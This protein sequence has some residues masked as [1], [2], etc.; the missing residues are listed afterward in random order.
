MIEQN[1]ITE[2]VNLPPF[3]RESR[4]FKH[5]GAINKIFPHIGLDNFELP[6]SKA[7]HQIPFVFSA[8]SE[9]A[10]LIVNIN[11]TNGDKIPEWLKC[12]GVALF[13][14][15]LWTVLT[16]DMMKLVRWKK[17]H[18]NLKIVFS[19]DRKEGVW[20]LATMSM[21]GT[22]SCMSWAQRKAYHLVGSIIDPY[23]G[24][25]Y[26]TNGIDDG[27]G[28]NM[29]CRAVVRYVIHPKL[30][31]VLFLE[32]IYSQ[33]N[34]I[35]DKT[36]IS[37]NLLFASVL[38]QKSRL[39]IIYKDMIDGDSFIVKDFHIPESQIV[40]CNMDVA[41]YRDSGISYRRHTRDDLNKHRK[42]HKHMWCILDWA[43]G[44]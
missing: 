15:I 43:T 41:S 16:S 17:K 20:D 10:K 33:K 11:G 9:A 8:G 31:P 12:I 36:A 42:A 29:N 7:K 40:K 1:D 26:L 38:K 44:C 35:D 34:E 19:S 5:T 3:I 2:N 30:G 13:S 25:I 18:S 24:I 28:P 39:P 6:I 23:C 27:Y 37:I 21:R 22:P 32:K 4:V 14:P